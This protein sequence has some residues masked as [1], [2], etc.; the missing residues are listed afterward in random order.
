MCRYA[1]P[2][3][4]ALEIAILLGLFLLNGFFAMA[5]IAVVSSR[6][7]KL[8]HMAEAGRRGAKQALAL[9]D[10]P[11]RFLSAVQVGITLIGIFSGA[12]GGG[13]LGVRLGPVLDRIPG[14]APHSHQAAVALVVIANTPLSAVL[15]QPL[16]KRIAPL[17]SAV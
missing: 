15:G 17:R 3:D 4:V 2:M 11:G 13:T 9:T 12:Y 10:N 16:P 7:I 5:E 14:G 8:Q 6:R 1:L